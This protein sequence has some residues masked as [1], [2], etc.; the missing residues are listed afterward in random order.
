MDDAS[1]PK[2]ARRVY[3]AMLGSHRNSFDYGC[4]P[5]ALDAAMREF[6]DDGETPASDWALWIHLGI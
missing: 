5:R 2:V 6:R 3:E 1:G 4:I